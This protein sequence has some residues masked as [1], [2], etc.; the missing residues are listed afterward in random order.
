M[1]ILDMY[2]CVV[3]ELGGAFGY[4]WSTEGAGNARM[5]RKQK[6]MMNEVDVSWY[7]VDLRCD[8]QL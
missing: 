2:W 5:M 8:L 6:L 4:R 7:L 1:F 3:D